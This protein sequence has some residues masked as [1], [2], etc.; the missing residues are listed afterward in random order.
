MYPELRVPLLSG[1]GA[2]M[3]VLLWVAARYPFLRRL[4]ARQLRRRRTEALLVVAGS[5]LGTTMIV[6][7]LVVGDTLNHSVRGIA[8]GTLGPVDERVVSLD[9]RVGAEVARRLAPLAADSRV[10]GV[11]T[12]RTTQAAALRHAP[13]GDRAEPRTLLWEADLTAAATFGGPESGVTGPTPRGDEVV[14]N[15]RLADSLDVRAGDD[16]VVYPFATPTRVRIVRVI[17]AEGLGGLGPRAQNPVVYV[18]PGTLDAAAR[19]AKHG[20]PTWVT[21]VSNRGGVESGAALTG[22]VRDRVAELLA[23]VTGASVETPKRDVLDAADQTGAVLGSLFLF[24]SSFS[25]IAGILL[26]VNVFVMLAEER[27]SE[28]GMLRAM[29]LRRGRLVGALVLEGSVYA[30]VAAVVGVG[31]GVSVGRGVVVVAA[32]VFRTFG[33]AFAD[34]RFDVTATSLV[35][36]AAMGFLIAFLT[37]AVASARISRTNVI[38]AIR[39]LDTDGVRTLRRR[40]LALCAIGVVAFGAA[41]VRAVAAST[42]P[43]TYA[44]PAVT[45]LCAMP[46]LARRLPKRLVYSGAALLVLLWGLVANLVRP[47]VFDNPTSTTYVVL[48]TMLAFGAVVL[49]AENQGLLLRPFRRFLERP[50]EAGLSVRLAVAYP[51]AK[52]FRTGATLAMYSIVVLMLVMITQIGTVMMAGV[53]SAVRDAAG[54]YDVRADFAVTPPSGDPAATLRHSAV[55]ADI[56]AATS[57]RTVTATSDDPTGTWTTPV[58]VVAVGIGDVFAREALP[59][60]DRQPAYRDDAA[61]WQAVL[62][63]ESLVVVGITFGA[64]GGPIGHAFGPGDSLTVTDP[65]SGRAVRRT[66]AA[67]MKNDLGFDGMTATPAYAVVMGDAAVRDQFG[68]AAAPSSVFVELRPGVDPQAFAT[69]VQA[70]L[71][72]YGT[73]ATAIEDRVRDLFAAN[74]ALFRL[75]QGFLALGLVVGITG[76]GVVMVRAVRERRRT[77]GVLRALGFRART[78]RRAFLAESTLIAVEGIV[79]GAVLAILT[80]WLLFTNSPAFGAIDAAFPIAWGQVALIVGVTFV[81]SLLAT[82]GPANRAAGIRP[83]LAL[84]ISD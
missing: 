64:T 74:L 75:M 69:R 63:D 2:A 8:Y 68:A 36:G 16:I 48:G 39:D 12:M 51:T 25:I 15:E 65:R 29:G 77:I 62:H 18:A 55:G 38:A 46:L 80:S 58:P 17:P 40:T 82:L 50:S 67:T 42:G 19:L 34:I 72:S 49:I 44:L 27:R 70:D 60:A 4:A 32:R 71:I 6:S 57:L 33:S 43:A 28:I 7:S 61:A 81:A 59:L 3:A 13:R 76:L 54:R 52:R 78:V 24:I 11:L 14:V 45:V 30:A 41:S 23:G 53:D 35:N 26:L 5:L 1:V 56:A 31:L 83:A 47:D 21:F 37:V 84:R 20:A 66:I 9:P 79:S 22:P 10:D 73:R